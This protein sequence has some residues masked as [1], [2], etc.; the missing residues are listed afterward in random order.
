MHV[1][2]PGGRIFVKFVNIR[3]SALGEQGCKLS[4]GGFGVTNCG[5]CRS[6]EVQHISAMQETWIDHGEEQN[7]AMTRI[8]SSVKRAL[9]TAMCH[10]R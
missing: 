10:G 6:G 1:P 7:S 4:L 5:V 2:T 9:C 8:S 3:G